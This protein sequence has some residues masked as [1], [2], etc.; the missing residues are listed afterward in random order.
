MLVLRTSANLLVSAQTLKIAIA[1]AFTTFVV[2]SP[3]ANLEAR[4]CEIVCE[5]PPNCVCSLVV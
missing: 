5:T 1:L 4:M 3:T 2:A